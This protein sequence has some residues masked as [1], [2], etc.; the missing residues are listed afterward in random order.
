MKSLGAGPWLPA[1]RLRRKKERQCG[2][3]HADYGIRD[4][5]LVVR[6]LRG[7]WLRHFLR[8]TSRIYVIYNTFCTWLPDVLLFLTLSA[9]LL[10]LLLIIIIIVMCACF[11]RQAVTWDTTSMRRPLRIEPGPWSSPH[12]GGR[13]RARRGRRALYS[14]HLATQ[15]SAGDLGGPENIYIYIYTYIHIYIYIYIYIYKYIYIYIYIY[16]YIYIYIYVYVYV[17]IFT[18]I[19]IYVYIDLSIYLSIYLS[20]YLSLYLSIYIY[21]YIYS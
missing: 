4:R 18:Y 5:F 2:G 12:H 14:P 10:L 7:C 20:L 1:T 15:S 6:D 21:I 3:C 17:Y 11:A 19:Y 16:V 8:L 9:L 13:G